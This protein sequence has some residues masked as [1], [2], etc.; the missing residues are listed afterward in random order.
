MGQTKPK[1]NFKKAQSRNFDRI[2]V[3]NKE[4]CITA[5]LLTRLIRKRKQHKWAI[6]EAKE[7]T[8]TVI[9]K[10]KTILRKLTVVIW[11]MVI[12]C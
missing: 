9:S 8:A 2:E 5:K 1:V 10:A 7:G 3:N 6:T 11:A 12:N 4:M